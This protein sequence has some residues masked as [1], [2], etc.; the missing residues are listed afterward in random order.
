[1]IWSGLNKKWDHYSPNYL[2]TL[3][4]V[5]GEDDESIAFRIF[6]TNTKFD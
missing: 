5:S 2:I 3:K 6:G 1:M 4:T